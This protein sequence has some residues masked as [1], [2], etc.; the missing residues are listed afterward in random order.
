MG[1]ITFDGETTKRRVAVRNADGSV[2]R[3]ADK[4]IVRET[5]VVA[6]VNGV[7]LDTGRNALDKA[8]AVAGAWGVHDVSAMNAT[9]ADEADALN[10]KIANDPANKAR[11]DIKIL[12]A[13]RKEKAVAETVKLVV[14]A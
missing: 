14:P 10:V 4:K 13:G 7:A 12:A 1:R 8:A 2:K 11:T 5:V 6:A 3:D 9:L